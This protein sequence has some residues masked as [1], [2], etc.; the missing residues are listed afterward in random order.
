MIFELSKPITIKENGEDK[1][2]KILNFDLLELSARDFSS[3]KKDW[4]RAGN[5]AI[6]PALDFDF[7]L[8]LVAKCLHIPHEDLYEISGVDSIRLSQNVSNFLLS[9]GLHSEM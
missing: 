5:A 2:V 7:C 3:V 4:M 8:M 9:S 6:S 1:E